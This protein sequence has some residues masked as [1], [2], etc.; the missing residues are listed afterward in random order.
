MTDL[1]LPADLRADDMVIRRTHA[2]ETNRFV[3][4]KVPGIPQDGYGVVNVIIGYRTSPAS[5]QRLHRW[6]SRQRL[7]PV[8]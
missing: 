6:A 5:N 2:V 4:A 3:T 7:I 1:L 8:K